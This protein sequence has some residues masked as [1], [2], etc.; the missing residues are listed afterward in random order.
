MPTTKKRINIT[1][2]KETDKILGMLAR[3]EN[4]PKAT[5]TSRLLNDALEIEE[6]FRLSAVAE[7]RMKDGGKYLLDKDAFWK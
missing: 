5:I 2:D 3:Q 7:K 4:V 6:D 1:V